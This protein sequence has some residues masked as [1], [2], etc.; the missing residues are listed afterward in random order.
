[1]PLI[2]PILALSLI[3]S[4]SV[5]ATDDKA[6]EYSYRVIASYPHNS[7]LFTQGL[8]FHDNALYESAGLYAASR[9]IKRKLDNIKPDTQHH[10]D[11]Y[12]FAEGI[13]LLND[14]LYQLTWKSEQGFIY[15]PDSLNQIGRFKIK[16]QG[17]GLTTDGQQLI[18][19][20]GSASLLFI[21]PNTFDISKKITVTLNGQ[22]LNNLNELEWVNGYIYAN[23]WN[24]NTIV[25]INPNHG[26]VE[27]S[28]DFSGL[29][30]PKLTTR[31]TNVLNGIAFDQQ[32]QRLFITGKNW[33]RLFHV[34]LIHKASEKNSSTTQLP[35]P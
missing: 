30:D 34:E 6:I 4:T 21:N 33:P 8:I 12:F 15:D 24:S 17:W 22:P 32:Q 7:N 14:R 10:L 11:Q 1:M 27:A 3:L 19:S 16:G 26:K 31:Y 13:T 18:M 5:F 9:L 35:Q 28:V 23:V 20:N 2:I 25:L 29:L